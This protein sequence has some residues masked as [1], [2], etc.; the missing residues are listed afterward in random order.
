MCNL[1]DVVEEKGIKKGIQQGI[2]QIILNMQKN[3]FD[4]KSISMATGKSEEE[5]REILEK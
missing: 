5:I 4:L 1:S 2:E 3:G